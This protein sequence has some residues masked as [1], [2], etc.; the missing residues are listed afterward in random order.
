MSSVSCDSRLPGSTPFFES[1]EQRLLLTTLVGGEAFEYTDM[2]GNIVR[3]NLGGD[4][5]A[6]FVGAVVDADG[7]IRVGDLPGYI[8]SSSIGR[9]GISTG[10]LDGLALIGGISITDPAFAPG[11]I[12]FVD[13]GSDQI[14]LRALASMDALANGATYAFN[15]ADVTIDAT[16]TR[17][18]IQ[19]VRIDTVDASATVDS[20]LQ[21]ASLREDVMSTLSD[22]IP[23]TV[24]GFSVDPTDGLAYAVANLAGLGDMLY[25]IDR[26]SGAVNPVGLI[27]SGAV[28]NIKAMAFDSSGTLFAIGFNPSGQSQLFELDK[29][30][31]AIV[32]SNIISD[33]GTPVTDEYISMAFDPSDQLYAIAGTNTLHEIDVSGAITNDGP[34]QVG[35]NDTLVEGLAFSLVRGGGIRMIGLDNS[36]L[37]SATGDTLARLISI[38]VTGLGINATALCEPGAVVSLGGLSSYTEAGQSGPML[39]GTDGTVVYR[40]SAVALPMDDTGVTVVQGIQAADFRPRDGSAEENLLYFVARDSDSDRLYT[41][42]V[43]QT[44]RSAIQNSLATI[45]DINVGDSSNDVMSITWR[46]TD[47]AELYGYRNNNGVG[48][49]FQIDPATGAA[50][51]LFN[52]TVPDPAGGPNLDV[53]DI[54]GIE[55]NSDNPDTF[56]AIR[57][58][59]QELL[60]IDMSGNVTVLGALFDADDTVTPIRGEDL[61]GLAWAPLVF[62]PFTGE[63]GA[64]IATDATSDELVVINTSLRL[65]ST[66]DIFCIYITQAGADASIAIA[67]I[68]STGEVSP[69][70][71]NIGNMVVVN[72]QTGSFNS[73]LASPNNTGR[74]YIG[75]RQDDG[76]GDWI[77]YTEGLLNDRLGVRPAG[78]DDLPGNPNDVSA[79]VKVVANLLEYVSGHPSMA[80]KLL[81]MNLDRIF[82]MTVSRDGVVVVVDSD[83]VDPTGAVSFSDEVAIVDGS[84]GQAMVTANITLAG[85]G[86]TLSGIQGLDYG[87]VNMD[88]VEEL[89]AIAPVG[90]YVPGASIGGDL[91]GDVFNSPWG[92]TVTL[93]GAMYVVDQNAGGTFDLY[94]VNRLASGAIDPVT[95]YTLLG[96]IYDLAGTS[97]VNS[98]LAIE[99]DPLTGLLYVIGLDGDGDQTLFTVDTTPQN[100]DADPADEVLA[101]RVVKLNGGGET[102]VVMAL[103][104]NNNGSQLYAVQAAGGVPTLFQ[105]STATGVMNEVGGPGNGAIQVAGTAAVIDG[106]D[107]DPAGNLIAVDVGPDAGTGRMIVIDLTAPSS[108]VALTPAGSADANLAGLSSDTEGLFYSVNT[109][110]AAVDD[111]IWV[112]AGMTPTFGMLDAT[113]GVFTQIGAVGGGTI[114]GVAAMAFS[115][116]EGSVPGQ[117]GLYIVNSGGMLYEIDPTDGS[118]LSAGDVLLDPTGQ[119]V[120]ITSMDFNQSGKLFGQDPFYGRLVD[121]DI[122]TLGSGTMTVGANTATGPGSLR[123]TVGAIAY[124]FANDRYLAVDNAMSGLYLGAANE[125]TAAES[126]ALMEIIGTATDSPEGQRVDRMMIGGTLTGKVDATGSFETFYAGWI[127]TGD[128]GGLLASDASAAPDNFMVTGDIRNLITISS[129]GTDTG[130]NLDVPVYVTG[131]SMQVGGKVGQI[132]AADGIVGAVHVANDEGIPNLSAQVSLQREVEIVAGTI[133]ANWQNFLLSGMQPFVNDGFDQAQYVGTI[134]EGTMGEPDVI[135]ISGEMEGA[136][137][138]DVTDYYALGLLAGQTIT[139]QLIDQYQT[140]NIGVFDPDGRL[141]ASN[142]SDVDQASV[143][144]EPFRV[145]ADRPG[146]YRI[147]VGMASGVTAFDGSLIGTGT[148]T[149]DIK[150]A[151]DIGMGGI[152]AGT[153]IFNPGWDPAMRVSRGDLGAIDGGTS[154]IAAVASPLNKTV[155]VANGNLR[156]VQAESIGVITG[157][158]EPTPGL[159][160]YLDVSGD[161]GLVRSTVDVTAISATVGGDTQV[162]DAAGTFFGVLTIGGGL[163]VLRAG[164]MVTYLPSQIRVNADN[165]GSDG[166]IDLIDVAGDFGLLA[167]GGPQISTGLGG[168]VRYIRV[169]GNS[170]Q[171]L[172][173]SGGHSDALLTLAPNQPLLNFVDDSGGIINISPTP[174]TIDPVTGAPVDTPELSYRFHA[175]YGSGGAVL[176]DV[177][178]TGGMTVT[179]STGG[180]NSPVEIGLIEANGPGRA[181]IVNT[182]G[183]LELD[184]DP[185]VHDDLNVIILGDAPIDVFDVGYSGGSGNFTTIANHTGGEIVNVTA[186]TIGT[187]NSASTIGLAKNHTGAAVNPIAVLDPPNVFPFEQQHIGVVSGNILLA[188]SAGALGN[189]IVDGRIGTITANAGGPVDNSDGVFDGIAAPIYATGEIDRVNI[190]EGI[191]PSGS[192]SYAWSGIYSDSGI[193]WVI[194]S[195]VGADIRGNI[196][197]S[198]NIGTISLT[199]GSIINANI[200]SGYDGSGSSDTGLLFSREYRGIWHFN[201]TS[202][203]NIMVAGPGGVIG[204]HASATFGGN[205]S[206]AGGFGILNSRFRYFGGDTS[207]MGNTTVDGFG[208]RNVTFFGGGKQ[209]DIIATGRGN[210]ISTLDYSQ[211]VRFSETYAYDPATGTGGFDPLF[212]QLIS[213]LT[214]IHAFLGTSLVAPL[215]TAGMMENVAGRGSLD[216]GNIRA[217]A[218]TAATFNY[219]NS[220]AGI[221]TI[222]DL[223]GVSIIT[224]KIGYFKPG[225]NVSSLDMTI[226]GRIDRLNIGGD[227]MGTSS[228]TANGP[229][230]DIRYVHIAGD[231]DGDITARGIIGT[232]II[233]GDLTGNINAYATNPARYALGTLRL[234]GSLANG[235]LDINGSVGTIDVAGSLGMAGD[236]LHI[237]GDLRTLRVGTNRLVSG[238]ALALDLDVLGAVGSLDVT[239]LISGNIFVGG[240]VN[241]LTV[242]AD[243]VT[244][245]G[246]IITSAVT[247]L[248]GIRSVAVNGG[249]VAADIT[250]GLDL[251]T[252]KLTGGD[253]KAGAAVSSSFGNIGSFSISGGDLLGAVNAPNGKIGS[254]TVSGSDLGGASA[255]SAMAAG[256]LKIDGSVLAGA[257]INL[258][259]RMDQLRVGGDIQALASLQA[260]SAGKVTVGGDVAGSVILGYYA[261]TT[262]LAIG[263]DMT[264]QVTIAGDASVTIGRDLTGALKIGCDLTGMMVTQ[265]VFGGIFIGGSGRT[266]KVGALD[267]AMIIAG[268]NVRGLTVAGAVSNSLVQI[269]ASAG[270]DGIFGTGD[271]NE[272]GRMANLGTLSVG[273]AMTNTVLVVGGNLG[274]AT[275]TGGMTN[276]SVSSGLYVGSQAIAAVLADGTPLANI[277]EIRAALSGADRELYRGNFGSATVGGAGMAA[278][279]LTAGVDA[280]ADGNFANAATNNVASSLSGGQSKFGRVTANLDGN[281]T[282]LAD[283]GLPGNNISGAGTVTPNVTYSVGTPAVNGDLTPTNLLE[284]LV[285]SAVSGTPLSYVTAGGSVVTITVRGNGTVNLYD[286]AGADT[287]NKL[288]SLVISGSDS[289]TRV[290]VTTSTPGAVTI[291]RILTSDDATVASLTF[292]GDLVG[293][294]TADPDLWIDGAVGTFSFRDLADDWSG[295]IGGNV[296]TL[297]L[298]TQ[299]SGKLYI[300]GHVRTLTIVDSGSN[301]LL[302]TLAAAPTSDIVTMATD[303]AGNVWVFDAVTGNLYRVNVNTGAVVGA[304]VAVTDAAS[305]AALQLTSMDFLNGVPDMLYGTAVLN[306][307]GPTVELGALSTTAISLNTLAVSPLGQ[308]FAIQNAAGQDVLAE[309]SPIDGSAVPVGTLADVFNN[310]YNG[311]VLAM[312]FTDTGTLLAL[313]S[314]RDGTGGAYAPADGVA[315]V[316]IDTTDSNGDGFVRVSSP[317]SDALPGILLDGGAVINGFTAMAFDTALTTTYAVRRNLADTQ[318]ELVTIAMDGTVTLVGTVQIAGVDTHIIGMGFDESGNLIAYNNDGASAAMIMVDTTD[319]TNQSAWITMDGAMDTGIDAFAVGMSGLN[320]PTF[321]YDTDGVVGGMF[322]ANPGVVPTLGI[323]DTTTGRTRQLRGLAESADGTPLWASVAGLAVDNFGPNHDIHVVTTDG[324]LHIYDE[325]DGSFVAN[326]GVITDANTAE[327]LAVSSI[328]FD[329]ATGDLIGLDTLLNRP[330]TIDPATGSAVADTE[331][332]TVDGVGLT[333]LTYDPI[334]AV[335]YSFRDSSDTFVAFRGMTQDALGGI[336][337]QSVGRLNI[338]GGA[339][340]EGRVVATGNTFDNVTVTGGFAGSIVTGSSIGRFTQTGG[341]FGGTL[342]AGGGIGSASISGG[343]FLVAGSMVAGETIGRLTVSGGLAGLVSSLLAGSISFGGLADAS[344][345]IYTTGLASRISFGG[346]FD[347]RAILGATDRLSVAGALGDLAYVRVNGDAGSVS[348]AGGTSLFS[349]MVI[350]GYVGSLSIGGTHSGDIAIREGMGNGRLGNI[351]FGMLLVGENSGSLSVGRDTADALISFGTWVGDDEIY[352]TAD[353]VITGGSVRSVTFGGEFRDSGVVAGV[354]PDVAYGPGMPLDMRAYTGNPTAGNIADIDSAEAGGVLKSYISSLT[355]RG[356]IINTASA[357]GWRAVAAAADG[358]SRT[359]LGASGPL[360]LQRVYGDPFGAPYVTNTVAV[361]GQEARIYFSEPV[362][363]ASLVLSQDLDGDGSVT[364]AADVAGTVTVR[365]GTGEVLNDILLDYTTVTAADGTVEGVL[366]LRRL[367]GFNVGTLSITLSGSLV[368]AAVY[369]RSGLRSALRDL[370]QDGTAAVGEDQAGTI[371]DGDLDGVEGGD[372]STISSFVDAPDTFDDALLDAPV[373]AVVDA[374]PTVVSGQF[375]LDSD[376]DVFRFSG[377]AYDYVSINYIGSTLA[378]MCLF[379]QDNQGTVND[380][381]DDYFEAMARYE[382][383][384]SS[385][386]TLFTA[387]ELPAAGEYFLAIVPTM[388]GA[389]PF[390]APGF[391]PSADNTYQL[392]FTLASSDDMLDGTVDG[393]TGLPVGKEIAYVS[394][395]VGDHNNLLGANTPRQLVYLDFDGGTA[396]KYAEDNAIPVDP[397]S[398][399]YIDPTLAGY[400]DTAINGGTSVVG[401]VDNI[402]AIFTNTPASN[403]AGGITVQRITTLSEWTAAADGLCFTTVD[404]ATW[405]LDPETDFTTIFIGKEDQVLGTSWGLIGLASNIDIAH[406]SPADN[407]IVFAQNV[408]NFSTAST[409]AGRLNDYSRL[410]ANTAAHELSHT[411]GLNHQPTSGPV[412]THLLADDPD[413]DPLTP[414]DSNQ[415]QGLMAYDVP[416]TDML[417]SL[418]ELGTA[419]LAMFEFPIGD[420]DTADLLIRWLA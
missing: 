19:L 141:V 111:E 200:M 126:A 66:A 63:M 56:F 24:N 96:E 57:N 316:K 175:I 209:G 346:D 322:Y 101:T 32:G 80:D 46:P 247:A 47:P 149:I 232:V 343:D 184:T 137:V 5:I 224:G 355:I 370:N 201:L 119:P 379:Y 312:A 4:I 320:F 78:E 233:D 203:G 173:I 35:G 360:L 151:G 117:Q 213:P 353:D 351:D 51:V 297:S 302:N 110:G 241:R 410:L 134:R 128:A 144:N 251:G 222:S 345:Q 413:N 286:E 20:M 385:S 166:I 133:S 104:F 68:A 338:G 277:A 179:S 267:S 323:I 309:I 305:G 244:A 416:M 164:D 170:Y 74:V 349:S 308:C 352:N 59:A 293:D 147:V 344:G 192:G 92:I 135:R 22:M 2:G 374:G 73:A 36:Q 231:M 148:Y 61:Q 271:L 193:N 334:A 77:P 115:P 268:Y 382:Y 14:D 183:D 255:I 304:A 291:G 207:E 52:I 234:G 237:N 27:A 420:I 114:A 177:H 136:A 129:I 43:E 406:Q 40:G 280:G 239:G 159:Y 307:Q 18:V 288:D 392:E 347:G 98:V 7:N 168:N 383:M 108:S 259:G 396:T 265:T 142:V 91:G 186:N 169:G 12:A 208:I 377:N 254:L 279:H 329:D 13:A 103:A 227:L 187:L 395:A 219:G 190:G 132:W 402:M 153:S 189:F 414:D 272:S 37:D 257:T 3:V 369:D 121:I 378:E 140:L 120:S 86:I 325:L 276:S 331:R 368:N 185:A 41:I 274:R 401:I 131:F 69:Y 335:F 202:W 138:G 412:D 6:E 130:S 21:Q 83:Q 250:A 181:V 358:I 388:A 330:V 139:V 102:D 342:W 384:I 372:S 328:E 216:V 171:D 125:A 269:G 419:P 9:G 394:N 415:G 223:T 356:N 375:D 294:G 188:R 124:D 217:Y 112:S 359:S 205:I 393:T 212:D 87:D 70:T 314:D 85:I 172:R 100:L 373:N 195:G 28:Q 391:D 97:P 58:Q 191:A 118:L 263:R 348:I 122:S 82:N 298:Q 266:I 29:T 94:Q 258:I 252:F 281:S 196:I 405:G 366:I 315:L 327:E 165:I 204:L 178:S 54:T 386:D 387:F 8:T 176:I 333:S 206:V 403:P 321:A 15:I 214:D 167:R 31:A 238:S 273:G 399:D 326:R 301:P 380:I 10:G 361:N 417:A 240:S 109:L 230:G 88:G 270:D 218:I 75:A 292:D 155:E 278:S 390:G 215:D 318:D 296:Q 362:N 53:D 11:T 404:P 336:T 182:D 16:T 38:S 317:T 262:S 93:G 180:N 295:Q 229:N 211:T 283:S 418:D 285:G 367:G 116:S 332:G 371:L 339:G 95:P 381:S 160:P 30:T 157:A 146:A 107:F 364:G 256:R 398:F 162:I 49:F 81:G 354:L 158:V 337:V 25:T 127:I 156:S 89:Y 221:S 275:M 340:Y 411:L 228:I 260:G 235:S 319:P 306:N 248:G 303:S 76:S 174:V 79:G 236:S 226:A 67:A 397:F 389:L 123:P 243:A 310:T 72:A 99:S 152:I 220:I 357:I 161:L 409:T 245:G 242:N 289:R 26:V 225:G 150:G 84:S 324:K 282:V 341:D 60:S 55:F 42:D 264:G 17:T 23:T 90:D 376:V 50:T 105:V 1:L 290:T 198:G 287:D 34:I 300:G 408:A 249:N 44:S 197:S 154:F 48:E 194:G 365:S 65:G 246:D 45:G 62:N 284:T 313:V 143:L 106:M 113:S 253:L 145:T 311:D 350:Y 261:R 363:T 210:L 163:G 400:E 39:F 407:A 299:G 64:L 199:G 33:G 71:G